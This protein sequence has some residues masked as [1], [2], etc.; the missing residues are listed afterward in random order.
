MKELKVPINK[1][2]EGAQ[3]EESL[4]INLSHLQNLI[5]QIIYVLIKINRMNTITAPKETVQLYYLTL[6]K[7]TKLIH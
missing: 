2:Q 1:Q 6:N 7:Y 3:F 4:L 5:S